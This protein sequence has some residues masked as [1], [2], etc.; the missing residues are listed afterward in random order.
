VARIVGIG[1]PLAVFTATQ[2]APLRMNAT[3]TVNVGGAECNLAVAAARLGHD[4]A[5]LAKV[6]DDPLGEAIRIGLR[7]EGVDVTG[8]RTDPDASTGIMVKE[9]RTSGR[10]RVSYARRGSAASRL[11]VD[12]LDAEILASAE[13]VHST[14]ITASLSDAAREAVRHA[15]R[16]V[17]RN[18]GTAALDVNYR[19]RLWPRDEAAKHLEALL[20]DV[21]VLFLTR[22]EAALLLSL[23]TEQLPAAGELTARVADLG[24][25]EVVLKV[26]AENVAVRVRGE[27]YQEHS[28]AVPAIDP[29]G[30]GDA[31]A[32]GYL[33]GRQ[34]GLPLDQVLRL[35]MEMGRWAVTTDG[36]H[37]GLPTREELGSL[38]GDDVAR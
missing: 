11:R 7:G 12:D 37:L 21:D 33:V 19:K 9:L 23:D 14:G 24:A 20:P 18:G 26:D 36:D 5:V 16:T 2:A 34:E 15:Y 32:A 28:P 35:A 31:F 25:G 29:V 17:R 38:S 30:A 3:F 10:V 4:T 22:D 8:L 1:E 13:L 6:G 27:L